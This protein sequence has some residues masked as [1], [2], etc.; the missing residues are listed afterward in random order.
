MN[1]L[2]VL[3]FVLFSAFFASVLSADA[4]ANID[5]LVSEFQM[6]EKVDLQRD[7]MEELATS[8]ANQKKLANYI[9]GSVELKGSMNTVRFLMDDKNDF[10]LD[11]VGKKRQVIVSYDLSFNIRNGGLNTF[12]S[13]F[14]KRKTSYVKIEQKEYVK[15]SA[16]ES[17][18]LK[19][20][21]KED[22]CPIDVEATPKGLSIAIFSPSPAGTT[23]FSDKKLRTKQIAYI[24]VP[25]ARLYDEKGIIN[26]TLENLVFADE[27]KK[28]K[29]RNITEQG[30]FWTK[31]GLFGDNLVDYLALSDKSISS[32][33][34]ELARYS[35]AR[36]KAAK[37]KVSGSVYHYSAQA[38]ALLKTDSVYNSSMAF[39]YLLLAGA[40]LAHAASDPLLA[41]PELMNA[42]G[43]LEQAF[44][45]VQKMRVSDE[46]LAAQLQYIES[47]KALISVGNETVQKG[48]NFGVKA[49]NLEVSSALKDLVGAAS[50]FKD[51]LRLYQELAVAPAA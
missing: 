35:A 26:A 18:G 2:N 38:L 46:V 23:D 19:V 17:T 3:F 15:N 30:F 27:D 5:A 4:P 12:A 40:S 47:V 51:A 31:S 21:V 11:E 41:I 34:K 22:R 42:A 50:L 28:L 45:H 6:V 1:K 36:A 13:W 33:T 20:T 39:A 7:I 43:S 48:I 49:Y 44:V 29:N 25:Y 8:K 14:G 10:I 9:S 32:S 37:T 16:G 24:H